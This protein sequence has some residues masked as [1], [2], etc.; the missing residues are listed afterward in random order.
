LSKSA[1]FTDNV[2]PRF[3]RWNAVTCRERRLDLLSNWP[4]SFG[5][6][7][8][9]SRE[10]LQASRLRARAH[11]ECGLWALGLGRNGFVP[12]RWDIQDHTITFLLLGGL[13]AREQ[14]NYQPR[15]T[16]PLVIGK[17]LLPFS[18]IRNRRLNL[19]SV[20]SRIVGHS[21]VAPN[22]TASRRV[23][24]RLAL[25]LVE[26]EEEVRIVVDHHAMMMLLPSGA[27]S[28]PCGCG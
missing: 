17:R 11:E 23:A 2:I 15:G 14:L 12:A 5:T 6:R 3:S 20:S 19:N 16:A 18:W 22:T 8:S 13:P 24:Q 1:R 25:G 9:G 4:R 27:T 10:H 26:Q 7:G 28:S 21:E